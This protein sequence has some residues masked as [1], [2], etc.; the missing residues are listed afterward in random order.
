MFATLTCLALASVPHP[1]KAVAPPAIGHTRLSPELT[2]GGEA[3]VPHDGPT[4]LEAGLLL[5]NAMVLDPEAFGV[6]ADMDRAETRVK[7]GGGGRVRFNV[8]IEDDTFRGRMEAAAA[9][10]NLF[11]DSFSR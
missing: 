9:V 7:A 4:P 5:L 3:K 11:K 10:L 8:E 2:A 6:L 1:P